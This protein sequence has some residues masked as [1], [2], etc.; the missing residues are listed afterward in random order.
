L[1]R[2]PR[3]ELRKT[4][5]T[6]RRQAAWVV[7]DGGTQMPCVLWDISEAGARIAAPRAS[8]LPKVFG[9]FLTKDGTSRRFCHV[10]WRR[11][12]QLG[13]QFI[14]EASANIDLEPSP[15]W[16]RRRPVVAAAPAPATA[17]AHPAD[18][19]ASQILL[20]GCGPQLALDEVAPPFRWSMVARAMAYLLLAATA[21]FVLAGIENEADWA[22]AVCTS[23]AENFCR[24]PE[25]TGG[26]AFAIWMIY[27]AVSGM[28][29]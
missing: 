1:T 5:R 12:G 8:G 28:E 17:V 26:A 10:A 27:L 15:A 25:W 2:D 13:V 21:V 14:D 29:D 18:I 20:P 3:R 7:L 16:M 6:P 9:L 11:G 24:H 19:D 22:V 23:G 4:K